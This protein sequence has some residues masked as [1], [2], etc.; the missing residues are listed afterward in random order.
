MIHEIMNNTVEKT[1]IACYVVVVL[2]H[3]P[4]L[5]V[6]EYVMLKH[7]SRMLSSQHFADL[8]LGLDGGAGET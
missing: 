4:H 1:L 5:R 8:Y 2:R 7:D 6:P 3:L